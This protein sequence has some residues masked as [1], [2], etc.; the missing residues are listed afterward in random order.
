MVK[1]TLSSLLFEWISSA[2]EKIKKLRFLMESPHKTSAS[3]PKCRTTF[4]HQARQKKQ[5]LNCPQ[6][7]LVPLF[8]LLYAFVSRVIKFL[9]SLLLIH[10]HPFYMQSCVISIIYSGGFIQWF[11]L[12]KI[13]VPLFLRQRVNYSTCLYN[14]GSL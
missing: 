7:S 8:L 3:V 12:D 6:S 1:I 13:L 14:G 4:R 11:C 2:T 10:F 5:T 9:S